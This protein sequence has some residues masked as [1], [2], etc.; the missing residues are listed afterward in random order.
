VTASVGG[1]AASPAPYTLDVPGSPL[2]C[3]LVHGLTGSPAE[4]RLLGEHLQ[5]RG[6]ACTA[7]LLPGHGTRL[8][9]LH[10]AHWQDW[11]DAGNAALAALRAEHPSACVVGFSMGAIVAAELAHEHPELRAV[12]LLSPGYTVT[13][14]LMPLAPCLRCVIRSYPKGARHEPADDTAPYIWAYDRWS[15]SA[16]AELSALKR[17]VRRH[18]SSIR[19]PALVAYSRG[20]RTI[21]PDAGPGLFADWGSPDKE[22]LTLER[23]SHG[24]V[25]D[26][27]RETLFERVHAFL[28]ARGLPPTGTEEL[29]APTFS[30]GDR[31]G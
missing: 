14:R 29:P 9:D 21:G 17:V 2:G 16:A 19:V 23:S 10:H 28:S 12:A 11:V 4:M 31:H 6:I 25:L 13:N 3:L 22:L 5:A 30:E 15:V 26:V 20:D 1:Q 7:P 8:E 27:E 18:V 24:I